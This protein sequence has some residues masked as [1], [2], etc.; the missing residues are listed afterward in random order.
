MNYRIYKKHA[1]EIKENAILIYDYCLVSEDNFKRI[2]R[3]KNVWKQ[4]KNKT[5]LKKYKKKEDK[6][7]ENT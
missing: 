3:I 5:K 2:M 7:S 4:G 1:K 6:F